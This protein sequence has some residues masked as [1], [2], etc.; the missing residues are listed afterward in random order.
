MENELNSIVSNLVS[1]G[2]EEK[3]DVLNTIDKK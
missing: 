1:I 2:K 3:T